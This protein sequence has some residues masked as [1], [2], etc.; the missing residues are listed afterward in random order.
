MHRPCGWLD[1]GIPAQKDAAPAAG[2]GTGAGRQSDGDGGSVQS[3]PLWH[4]YTEDAL[5]NDKRFGADILAA[6]PVGGLLIFDLGFFSFLW[7][8]DF[9]TTQRFFV[10]RMR[11]KIAYRP[12]QV[13]SQ[14]PYYRDEIIQVG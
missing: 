11:E 7:F 12:V 4:L 9:T 1:P 14:G 3:P 10:T 2:G 13:L 5:A 6:L 8:D